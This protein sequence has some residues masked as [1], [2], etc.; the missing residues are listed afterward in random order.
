METKLRKLEALWAQKDYRSA[1]KLAAGWPRLGYH[2]DTITQAWAATSNR[3]F[4]EQLGHN[5][6]DL[7]RR[8]LRAI[9]E[10][11]GLPKPEDG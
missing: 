3:K 9:S 11:Y 1:L 7:Y 10:R 2:K 8:G 4:Y 6:D 5:P